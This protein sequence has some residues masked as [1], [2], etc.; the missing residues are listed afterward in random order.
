ML[1]KPMNRLW[2]P[3]SFIK[4]SKSDKHNVPGADSPDIPQDI[5]HIPVDIAA[6]RGAV[7]AEIAPEW[8]APARMDYI[9]V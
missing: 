3:L 9:A 5:F 2:Q 1:S 4:S 7:V 6:F 8:T